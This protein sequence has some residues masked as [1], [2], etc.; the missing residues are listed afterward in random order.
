MSIYQEHSKNV[1][2]WHFYSATDN[3]VQD[4]FRMVKDI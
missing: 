2:E 4:N 3:V 1:L